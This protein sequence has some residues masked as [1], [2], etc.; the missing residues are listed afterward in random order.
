[1]DNA[2]HV[3]KYLTNNKVLQIRAL[4][5]VLPATGSCQTA[6]AGNVEAA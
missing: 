6:C 1:M 5:L 3:S 2:S 4:E